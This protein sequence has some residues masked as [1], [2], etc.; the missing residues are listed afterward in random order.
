VKRRTRATAIARL[1]GR[2]ATA[3]LVLVFVSLIVVQ[4]ARIIHANVAMAEELARARADVR[5]LEER[6]RRDLEEIRRLSTPAGAIPLI[7]ERLRLVRP[8]EELIFL[9]RPLSPSPSP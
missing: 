7:H 8:N 9:E 5:A 6:K 3:S 2:L 4:F 1:A